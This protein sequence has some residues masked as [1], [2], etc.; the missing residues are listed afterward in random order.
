MKF[1]FS[2]KKID[3]LLVD[4][5]Q[6]PQEPVLK[7]PL[8]KVGVKSLIPTP[9]GIAINLEKATVIFVICIPFSIRQQ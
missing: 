9:K 5:P 4:L 1:Y 8:K 2:Q 3:S 7:N 6:V